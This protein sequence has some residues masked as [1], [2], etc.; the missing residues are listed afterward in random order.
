MGL[1]IRGMPAEQSK[2]DNRPA[3][4]FP[5]MEE[6]ILAFWQKEKIFERSV[7]ERPS[8]KE[9]VF[10]DGPPFATGLPHFGH[11]LASAIK[12]I[13][14]RY[15]TMQG[16]RVERRF[17]WDC[18]GLPV[19]TM[20][21]KELGVNS[22]KEI[23]KLGIQ[24]FND[25]CRAA[26]LRYVSEWRRIITRFGRW[27]DFD[28][29]YK[30]MDPKYMESVIWVFSELYK[31][32]LIYEDF[33]CSLYCTRCETP[34]SN[35]ETAMDNSYQ[36]VEDPSIYIVF[37]LADKPNTF[38]L[39][40]TT[41]PWTLSANVALA[42]KEDAKYAEV[43]L[44]KGDKVWRSRRFILA[45]DRLPFVL[46]SE[47]YTVINEFSGADLAG[48]KYKPIQDL[49]K[50]GKEAYRVVAADFVSL[51][52][53]TGLVHIA[54]AFGEDDFNISKKEN[55][56]M[57]LT[58]DG[59]GRFLPFISPWAGQHVKEADE[60]IIA[61]L[62]QEG[63]LWRAETIKHSYPFCWRCMSPLIY[64]VQTSWYVKVESIKSKMLL[65]NEKIHWVPEH[66]KHGR[67]R[68]GIEGAPDWGVSRSR[69]WGVPIPVWRCDR[70]KKERVVGGLDELEKLS[71]K[72]PH[73]LHRPLI[74]EVAWACAC[75]GTF[76]R[77]PEVFDVWFESGSMPYAEVHYPFDNKEKFEATFPADF[78]T[79]YIAQTRGWFYV[80]H[81]LSNAL[82][83]KNSFKHVVTT[84]T[85]LGTDG[86][87]MSKSKGNYPD[88]NLIFDRYGADAL[89][90]YFLASSVMQ[91][92]AV[93]FSESEIAE[94]VRKILLPFWNVFTFFKL[95]AP[96]GEKLKPMREPKHVLD[97]WILA[98]LEETRHGVEGAM[99]GYEL[100]R[101]ARPLA[102]FVND[103]STW[104]LRRS[105]DRFKSD[106]KE[107]IDEAVA[108]LYSVLVTAAKIFAPFTPFL[109]E[110]LYQNLKPWN[111]KPKD[112]V[113]L[114]PW[115][116]SHKEFLDEKLLKEMSEAREIIEI[117]HA[118]R[119]AKKIKVRQP[120][121]ALWSHGFASVSKNVEQLILDELNVKQWLSGKPPKG[122]RIVSWEAVAGKK[123]IFFDTKLTEDLKREGLKRE[124]VR[125][126]NALRKKQ[127]LTIHD[128][129]IIHYDT[130][131]APLLKLLKNH[132]AA[133]AKDVIASGFLHGEGEHELTIDGEVIKISLKR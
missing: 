128:K 57:V 39:S 129:I 116:K 38:F 69:Y 73:D 25:A 40:W 1:D 53:G 83:G 19:E 30:T 8:D 87:K 107:D 119:A 21:E 48:R 81:V 100:W 104:Y 64:K 7:N 75:G 54:P 130:D 77:V 106:N 55:L 96:E 59:G 89:R 105:R 15:K 94:A 97:K 110:H 44:N 67:F 11:L 93:N 3:F 63:K 121:A 102:N 114:E 117:G 74:D 99:E 126:I 43:E 51:D 10:Y 88:A 32:K 41:T 50:P 52:E 84:G 49:A 120:L 56:P 29:D 76:Q 14:P 85:I 71:G 46:A 108:S 31:K 132:D 26:V 101:V 4:S 60:K 42:V 2:Q 103:L 95:Y 16:F 20:V 131:S 86:T 6:E 36:E 12:D 5:K 47:P 24:K 112:S 58:V 61:A 98:R 27:V 17:G 78:I 66:L 125:Q 122:K 34:L 115:P 72:R 9:Y 18:H 127:G 37:E 62:K 123:K 92:E 133:I 65:T 70:C 68:K 90:Y 91:A 45:K 111:A 22:K 33:R 13:V 79:E 113:H 23:E 80:M 124:L 109:A 82:F 28:N 118:L 35:F